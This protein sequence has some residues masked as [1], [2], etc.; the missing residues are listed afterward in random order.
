MNKIFKK[1]N[2]KIR[3]NGLKFVYKISICKF[4][5][6]STFKIRLFSYCTITESVR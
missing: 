5:F 3:T 1:I 4:L 6:S 2:H